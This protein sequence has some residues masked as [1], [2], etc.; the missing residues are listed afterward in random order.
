MGG[1]YLRL[2]EVIGYEGR[3]D[4]NGAVPGVYR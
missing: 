1:C 4:E 2:R 3:I